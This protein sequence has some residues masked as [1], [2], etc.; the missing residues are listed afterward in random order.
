[1]R[2]VRDSL[3]VESG[4][5]FELEPKHD[6][7]GGLS[8]IIIEYLPTFLR[9]NPCLKES[10]ILFG[11]YRLQTTDYLTVLSLKGKVQ[12]GTLTTGCGDLPYLTSLVPFL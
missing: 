11:W 12:A 7:R 9:R 10:T 8:A 3:A 2:I 5:H 4:Q 1:M 6:R